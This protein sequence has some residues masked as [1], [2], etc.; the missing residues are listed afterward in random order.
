MKDVEEL[1]TE[2]IADNPNAKIP[3]DAWATILDA[4]PVHVRMW[5]KAQERQPRR[6][7]RLAAASMADAPSQVTEERSQLPTP[8]NSISPEPPTTSVP[9]PLPSPDVVKDEPPASPVVDT[10][11]C[12]PPPITTSSND[13][14]SLGLHEAIQSAFSTPLYP[15]P[16]TTQPLKPLLTPGPEH[17]RKSL[18]RSSHGT[19]QI[20]S[21]PTSPL[22]P[23]PADATTLASTSLPPPAITPPLPSEAHC[24]PPTS[25]LPE[26]PIAG[27]SK[28]PD[29]DLARER[30]T[31]AA[32]V[33]GKLEELTG[34][35]EST[36]G[37]AQFA[38]SINNISRRNEQFLKD[39]S[40]GRF[41]QLRL[42]GAHLPDG[43]T[44]RVMPE[45]NPFRALT[46]WYDGKGKQ[47]RGRD[48]E[49][50]MEM[51]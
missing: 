25:P 12:R 5:C 9:R 47:E 35:F 7:S 50:E 34:I 32:G 1:Y 19:L 30:A 4:K 46:E 40:A 21:R 13:N 15:P 33:A 27:P 3:C 11:P 26:E 22:I 8:G 23:A 37:L 44:A 31:L 14:G 16:P 36:H 38:G 2:L 42:T 51:D 20:V 10:T 17:R 45:Y 29:R 18:P 49:V 28:Q 48:G 43:Q 24:E 41:A 6:K 39:V